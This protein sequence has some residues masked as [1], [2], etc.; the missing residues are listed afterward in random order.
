MAEVVIPWA[1][2]AVVRKAPRQ[3]AAPLFLA[4][5]AMYVPASG[6]DVDP[7]ASN[8]IR[9][10]QPIIGLFQGSAY[11]IAYLMFTIAFLLVMTGARRRGMDVAKN[12]AV[13]F[14]GV[15]MVPVI[16]KLILGVVNVMQ[17]T[18]S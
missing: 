5:A 8:I 14:V 2:K 7:V 9:A 10:F 1:S 3:T 17:H 4:A 13:G 15:A 18:G 12:A 16:M 6:A 11:W